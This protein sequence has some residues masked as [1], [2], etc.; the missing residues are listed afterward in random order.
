MVKELILFYT[1]KPDMNW[2]NFILTGQLFTTASIIR[3]NKTPFM[4]V[5]AMGLSAGRV[6]QIKSELTDEGQIE[7]IEKGET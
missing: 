2:E 7:K 1:V 3:R 4:H 6:G 5:I